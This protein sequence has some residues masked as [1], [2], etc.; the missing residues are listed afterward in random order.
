M[1]P[2]PLFNDRLAGNLVIQETGQGRTLVR[3]FEKSPAIAT[4]GPDRRLPKQ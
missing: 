2:E 1:L 3:T 4:E